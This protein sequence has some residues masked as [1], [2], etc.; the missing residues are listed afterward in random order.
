MAEQRKKAEDA[1]LLALA[2]GATVEQTAR[3]CR[4]SPRTVYRRLAE[5]D[6]RRR[7]RKLRGDMVQQTAGTL[8][9]AASE[10]VRTLLELMKPSSPHAVWLPRVPADFEE[11]RLAVLPIMGR[12]LQQQPQLISLLGR[13]LAALAADARTADPKMRSPSGG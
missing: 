3:Q 11:A 7:L 4:L 12:M 1:L 10:A 6:F 2:C 8:T 9:A 5:A 13:M